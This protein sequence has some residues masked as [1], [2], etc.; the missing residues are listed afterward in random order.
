M[1]SHVQKKGEQIVRYY[2]HSNAPRGLRHKKNFDDL[3]PSILVPEGLNPNCNW[4]G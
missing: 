4:A 2:E 3:I 1:T